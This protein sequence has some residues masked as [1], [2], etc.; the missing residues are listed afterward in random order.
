[1]AKQERTAPDKQTI[2][3]KLNY[4]KL[5]FYVQKRKPRALARGGCHYYHKNYRRISRFVYAIRFPNKN[6]AQLRASE[7][8]D[9]N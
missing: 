4:P 7:L 6:P 9:G 8:L 2:L 3:T 5:G 1:M